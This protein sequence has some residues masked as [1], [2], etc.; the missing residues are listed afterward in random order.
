MRIAV[1]TI[2]HY[3]AVNGTGPD[4]ERC[5]SP[6]GL[7]EQCFSKAWLGLTAQHLSELGSSVYGVCC[8]WFFLLF[9]SETGFNTWTYYTG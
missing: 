5:W 2:K 7:P 3:H 8:W 1:I 9:I 6:V 4:T